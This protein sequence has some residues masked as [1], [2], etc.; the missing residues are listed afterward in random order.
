VR[1]LIVALSL[2]VAVGIVL[3]GCQKAPT[4]TGP[5]TV[6]ASAKPAPAPK[7]ED[8][9][10]AQTKTLTDPDGKKLTLVAPADT[11]FLKAAGV[12]E[13]PGGTAY[14]IDFAK[15]MKDSGESATKDQLEMFKLMKVVAFETKDSIDK[16]QTWAKDNLKDWQIKDIETK[17]SGKGFEATNKDETLN[18]VAFEYPAEKNCYIMIVDATDMMKQ[19]ESALTAAAAGMGDAAK[20]LT[21]E[22]AKETGKDAKPEP[23]K[24]N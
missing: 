16:I 22:A 2:C 15:E 12:P 17:D 14:S 7:V 6:K 5:G 13:Y 10:T 9:A 19:M 4:E 11:S 23:K 24:G 3:S 21:K 8:K 18:L 20:D 1:Y